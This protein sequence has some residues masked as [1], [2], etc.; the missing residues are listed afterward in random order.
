MQPLQS[1]FLRIVISTI[2]YPAGKKYT[3]MTRFIIQNLDDA[4]V[5]EDYRDLIIVKACELGDVTI[6]EILDER[7]WNIMG[8]NGSSI[9]SAVISGH[10]NLLRFLL[11]KRHRTPIPFQTPNLFFVFVTCLNHLFLGFALI[12][13]FISMLAEIYCHSKNMS[14]SFQIFAIM[15]EKNSVCYYSKQ[16]YGVYLFSFN[17]RQY[18]IISFMIFSITY[19]LYYRF[20]PFFPI[21]FGMYLCTK[22]YFTRR[23]I[24]IEELG[25][26][27]TLI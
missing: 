11:E 15:Q 24:D 19:G 25:S 14:G 9:F 20:V 3:K 1:I 18:N 12:T 16:Q 26:A 10:I 27:A 21:M 2:N 8:Q 17:S 23:R 4:A 22:E 6:F 5:D 7:R 13:S